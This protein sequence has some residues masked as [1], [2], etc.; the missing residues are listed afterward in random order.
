MKIHFLPILSRFLWV[1]RKNFIGK[2]ILEI[3]CGT[4]LPGILAAKFGAKVILSDSCSLPHALKH[5]RR[6][7]AA[8]NL[9]VGKDIDVIGLTWGILLKSVFDIAPLDY[10]IASDC[11]YD[12][13]VFEQILVTVAFLLKRRVHNSTAPVKFLFTYQ[14]R[15]SDWTIEHLLQKWKLQ[16]QRVSLKCVDRLLSVDELSKSHSIHLFEIT[17]IP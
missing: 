10:I 2:R 12:P 5:V 9:E 14:E 16:C 13:S 17:S 11:F 6:C 4:G 1:Q 7:C 3:G 15:S 8:N